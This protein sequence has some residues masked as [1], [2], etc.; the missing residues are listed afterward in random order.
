MPIS[1]DGTDP[2]GGDSELDGLTAA[3]ANHR[4]L[5]EDKFIRVLSVNIAPGQTEQLHHDRWPSVF[6]ESSAKLRDSDGDRH[7]IPLPIPDNFELPR[8]VKLPPQPLHTPCSSLK[9]FPR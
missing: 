1:M 9:M 7:Q 2:A 8:T 3:R 5:Y 6:V 4:L